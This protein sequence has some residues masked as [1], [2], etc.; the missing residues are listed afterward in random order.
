MR[1]YV[2]TGDPIP[3]LTQQEHAAF[4]FDL[5]K[6]ILLSLEKEN[7]LTTA[8]R[9]RCL[10]ALEKQYLAKYGKKHRA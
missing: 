3:T 5:Q 4:Q 7:V 9:N 2:Y 6:A 10:I 8:Q 1:K